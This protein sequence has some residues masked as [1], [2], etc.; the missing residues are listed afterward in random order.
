MPEISLPIAL[1]GC[2]VSCSAYAAL[3]TTKRGQRLTLDHTWLT[4]VVGVSIVLAWL[5]TQG[6]HTVATDF[7]FFA[8]GGT[9]LV[10][11]SGWLWLNHER[12]VV[13]HLR[14]RA[15]HHGNAND[16]DGAE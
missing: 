14:E 2:F 10:L 12:A 11:R 4:V 7:W 13:N 5:S 8:A 15:N 1:A 9:P 16:A 6:T 3:L